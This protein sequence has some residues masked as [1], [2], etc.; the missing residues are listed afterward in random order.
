MIHSA[1]CTH[2]IRALIHLATVKPDGYV[3]MHELCEGTDLPRPS[4]AKIFY[5]LVQKRLL[6]SA[7]GL[8]G[9]FALAR[10]IDRISLYDI[11]VAI[12]GK[13]QFEECVVRC[14]KCNEKQFCP[15]HDEWLLLRDCIKTFMMGTTLEQMSRTM[16]QK[17]DVPRTP[18]YRRYRRRA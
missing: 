3:P 11:V 5:R 9:G 4:V 2:A 6:N 16:Q 18:R 7:K 13:E 8:G 17:F 1:A 14:S 15:L 10:P 12:D